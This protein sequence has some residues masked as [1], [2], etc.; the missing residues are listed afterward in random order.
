M[1]NPVAR[2]N[3]VKYS[4]Q[5]ISLEATKQLAEMGFKTPS[6]DGIAHFYAESLEKL[7]AVFDHEYY[8]NVVVPDEHNF[9]KA[10]GRPETIVGVDDD[11]W[12]DGK[13]GAGVDSSKW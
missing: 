13:A 8:K 12:A 7:L 3:L 4:Q 9:I 5:H 2:T 11:K 1:G 10:S 6:A